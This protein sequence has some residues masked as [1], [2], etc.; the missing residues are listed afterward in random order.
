MCMCSPGDGGRGVA[1]GHAGEGG[2]GAGP[3]G[4]TPELRVQHGGHVWTGGSGGG[5]LMLFII[6]KIMKYLYFLKY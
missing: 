4:A 2:G 1:A 6:L 3:Q 5:I